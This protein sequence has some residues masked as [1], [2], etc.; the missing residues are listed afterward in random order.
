MCRLQSELEE[1]KDCPEERTY[2]SLHRELEELQR[3]CYHKQMKQ[4]LSRRQKR[5]H[6]SV[7]GRVGGVGSASKSLSFDASLLKGHYNPY[8]HQYVPSMHVDGEVERNDGAVEESEG[9][10]DENEGQA[11]SSMMVGD[12]EE[13]EGW[14]DE[15][16]AAELAMFQESLSVSEMEWVEDEAEEGRGGKGG[17]V[18]E[19]EGEGEHREKRARQQQTLSRGTGAKRANSN[20]YS[21]IK[22]SSCH[23]V[24]LKPQL[25]HSRTVVKRGG[26]RPVTSAHLACVTDSPMPGTTPPKKSSGQ[27][28][29]K[30]PGLHDP[31]QGYALIS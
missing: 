29:Y 31:M 20:N 23:T 26:E 12:E 13:G 15:L 16:E 30:A 21:F 9:R 7:S 22:P 24:H 17:E 8:T 11:G 6:Q 3:L 18:T 28:I 27:S 4:H 2:H 5:D 10:E 19:G 25:K 14:D 1:C